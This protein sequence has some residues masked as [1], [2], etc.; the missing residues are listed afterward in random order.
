MKVV[1]SALIYKEF[2]DDHS[3]PPYKEKK[4]DKKKN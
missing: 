2:G 3:C 4:L 1:T